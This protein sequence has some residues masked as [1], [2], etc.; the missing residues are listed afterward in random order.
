M[1]ADRAS[2]SVVNDQIGT[3]TNAVDLAEALVEI[4]SFVI[5]NPT[6]KAF[7]IYNF[8]NE[9]SCS[10]FDF[11]QKIFEIKNINIAVQ[12]I[13]TSSYPTPA[14]RPKYSVLD[15]TKIKT[16]FE[17]AIKNWEESLNKTITI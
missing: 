13:P 17:M 16:V 6:Q 5:Q 14:A 4:I 9:G 3:P 15:K 7:G 1:G 2:L 10:W 8:S 12:P 11:A